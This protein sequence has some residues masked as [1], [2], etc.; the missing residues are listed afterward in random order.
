MSAQGETDRTA[1]ARLRAGFFAAHLA[2]HPAEST[3]L[4][5]RDQAARLSDPGAAA[6]AAELGRRR[7]TLRAAQALQAEHAAGQ[8][9]LS[10]DDRLDLDAIDWGFSRGYSIPAS[11]SQI[12]ASRTT[13]PSGIRSR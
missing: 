9:R 8:R 1:A 6:A 10:V 3:T 5:L 2:A 13:P 4:G 7:E 12:A 11:R